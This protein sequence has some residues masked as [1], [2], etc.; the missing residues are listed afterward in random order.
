MGLIDPIEYRC[1]VTVFD[2]SCT[3][4]HGYLHEYLGVE[5][6]FTDFRNATPGSNH[7]IT[8][9]ALRLLFPFLLL[10]DFVKH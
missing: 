3:G 2:P 9:F 6:M 1:I 10:A 5:S 4:I 8:S 7:H